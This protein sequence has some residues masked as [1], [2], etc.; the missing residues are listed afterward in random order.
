MN[1]PI[2]ESCD[3]CGACCMEQGSPPG[4]A[5]FISPSEDYRKTA[6]EYAPEDAVW[7]DASPYIAKYILRSYF[8]NVED[9]SVSGDG[10]CCWLDMETKQCR[11][12]EHR[13]SVCR[14]FE[15]SSK[16]CHDWRERYGI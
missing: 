5:D 9:D 2:I 8:D 13:P 4:F 15:R 16:P 11:F 14:D 3:D 12:Y 7:F 1:L 6:R 10:P